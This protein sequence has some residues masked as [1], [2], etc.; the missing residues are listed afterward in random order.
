MD[1]SLS[2]NTTILITGA[3]GVIGQVLWEGLPDHF[4]RVGLDKVHMEAPRTYV[5]D[6]TN[7]AALD[8]V[9][10]ASPAVQAIVHLAADSR[11][12]SP[13][14]A[15]RGAGIDGT[16]TVMA[17]AV[18]HG[19]SRVVY[20]SSNHVVGGYEADIP[21]PGTAGRPRL[22]ADAEPRPD[23]LY[24]V[25]K[26]AGEALGRYFSEQHGLRVVCLRIGSVRRSDDPL[27][28]PRLRRTWL[29]HRDL[30]HLV[31]RSLRAN[32][33]FGIYYGVSAN[34]HRMWDLTHAREEIGYRPQDN[35]EQF[36][37]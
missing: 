11:V 34:T 29:S 35:G 30:V 36:F 32:V 19:V 6:V 9:L 33:N 4:T 5:G 31:G 13:W 1:S 26:L 14:S 12:D 21:L 7:E 8:D 2:D 16:R 37:R 23:S 27:G 15:V 24:G 22:S 18:R 3:A 20:A 17:A 28:D 25:G 10:S